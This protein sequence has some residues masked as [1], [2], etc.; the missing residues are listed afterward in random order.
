MPEDLITIMFVRGSGRIRTV[1][2]AL[3]KLVIIGCSLLIV[4]VAFTYLAVEYIELYQETSSLRS[5]AITEAED[6]L[7]AFQPSES[8]VTEPETTTPTDSLASVENTLEQAPAV[9]EAAPATHETRTVYTSRD[10]GTVS[11]SLLSVGEFQAILGQDSNELSISFRLN[12]SNQSEK[13]T[14]FLTVVI[15]QGTGIKTGSRFLTYPDAAIDRNG[16]VINFRQGDYFAI[17]RW[18]PV[19][20]D[21]PISESKTAIQEISIFVYSAEGELLLKKIYAPTQVAA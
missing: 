11:S 2:I 10:E 4:M 14:G 6:A 21:I 12:N 18:K 9:P 5:Q 7:L 13:I 20:V 1:K 8:S 15:D 3:R 16:K 17:T 19:E